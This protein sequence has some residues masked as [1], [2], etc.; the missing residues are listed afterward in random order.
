MPYDILVIPWSTIASKSTFS[1]GGRVFDPFHSS[2][3]PIMIEALICS[4][5]WLRSSSILIN[6]RESMVDF[7][8]YEK[9]NACNNRYFIIILLLLIYFIFILL[10]NFYFLLFINV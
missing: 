5:N 4:Q 10:L 3:S 1:M 9:I 7:Q 8:Q 6:Y 2:L